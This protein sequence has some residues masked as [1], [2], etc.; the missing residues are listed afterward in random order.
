MGKSLLAEASL[1]PARLAEHT[2]RTIAEAAR[3]RWCRRGRRSRRARAADP[4]PARHGYSERGVDAAAAAGPVGDPLSS[5]WPFTSTSPGSSTGCGRSCW[6]YAALCAIVLALGI[7][8]LGAIGIDGLGIAWLVAQSVVAAGLSAGRAWDGHA[9]GALA[10]AVR[11][12]R[13]IVRQPAT[14]RPLRPVLDALERRHGTGARW[15]VR[16]HLPTVGEVAV[17]SPVRRT[18]TPRLWSSRAQRRRMRRAGPRG[19]RPGCPA[20]P[21]RAGEFRAL[22]PRPLA[23]GTA[24]GQAFVAETAL[25]GTPADRGLRNGLTEERLLAAAEHAMRPL[26]EATALSTTVDER[27]LSEWVEAPMAVL[28][29]AVQGRLGA[30]RE[31]AFMRLETELRDSLL[32]RRVETSFVHGDLWAGNLLM[33]ELGRVS[34]I[35]DWGDARVQGIARV[36]MLHLLLT[37]RAWSERKEIGDVVAELLAGPFRGRTP[38][39][40]RVDARTLLLLAWLQH[41]GANLTKETRYGRSGRWMRRNIDP[42]LAAV[43]GTAAV[44][45]SR[46]RSLWAA[47][48]ALGAGL[49]LWAGSIGAIDP[50]AM[51]DIGLVSVLPP[52]FFAAILALTAAFALLVHRWPDRPLP[53]AGA[54]AAL[55]VLLHATPAIVYGTLRY[56]WAWKHVG[57]V[58]YIQRHGTVSP[59]IDNLPVYHNWPGFFGLDALLTELAG[60]ADAVGQAMWAPL[61]FNL[62]NLAALVFLLSGLTRDRRVH[63]ARLLAVLRG[64]L[65]GPGL[66]LPPGLCVLPLPGDAGSACA[67]A[68]RSPTNMGAARCSRAR[69]RDRGQP[70]THSGDDR[71]RP[72]RPRRMPRLRRAGAAADRARDHSRLEPDVRLSLRAREH[73]LGARLDPASL[74]D[75]R[76]KPHRHRDTEPRPGARRNGG[77]GPGGRSRRARRGRRVSPLPLRSASTAPPPLWRW[78]PW[79]SSPGATT[80]GRSCS[81]STCSPCRS[82]PSSPRTHSRGPARRSA[83]A[84]AAAA[85]VMVGAFLLA[86]YGKE[87]QYHFTPAEVAASRYVYAHAPPGSLL[88]EGTRNYPGQFENYERLDYVTLSREP[89]SSHARFVARP[90]EVMSEWMSAHPRRRLPDHHPQPEGRGG[91]TRGDAAREPRQDRAGTARLAPLHRGGP[92]LGRD[93][94]HVGEEDE[95][96]RPSPRWPVVVATSA[97]ALGVLVLADAHGA[98]RVGAAL[99]FLIACPGIAVVPLFA[100]VPGVARVALVLAVSLAIDTAVVTGMLVAGSFSTTVGVLTLAVVCLVGCGAQTM[101]WVGGRPA[102]EVRLHD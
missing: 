79:P 74:D 1:D 90:V 71:A 27:L 9:A 38:P 82:W 96:M 88:I 73:R 44:E 101:R 42:V 7:P 29:Q 89:S 40:S 54:L 20:Q 70:P 23:S 91:G 17:A 83:L 48:G 59:K 68:A 78:P 35:V 75:H 13:G 18:A 52:A 60:L 72:D 24:G 6:T 61:F 55:I 21:A 47:T 33:D 15:A 16:R 5:S 19:A 10:G 41:V 67:L 11:R 100:D 4:R 87:R 63:L 66:L 39:G 97:L 2:R 80:A 85:T 84:F 99:W 22:A 12:A 64:E 50:R 34:G 98:L 57:V 86:Y 95:T 56:S 46:P 62:L 51:T 26:Y 3:T 69:R 92:Q 94:V 43:A 8:L 45:R 58:D 65:G 31:E 76:R 30:A 14:T 81:A 93:G 28:R 77:P 36:D 49:A 102:T 25:P 32:G 53:L 37:T